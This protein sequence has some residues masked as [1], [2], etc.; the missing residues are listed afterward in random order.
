VL[1][2]IDQRLLVDFFMYEV[3]APDI[4]RICR[5]LSELELP[6]VIP[7]IAGLVDTAPDFSALPVPTQFDVVLS[8]PPTEAIAGTPVVDI[9]EVYVELLGDL[10]GASE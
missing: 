7:D 6:E 5:E 10:E 4:E 1:R 3:P 2:H 9:G 8:S